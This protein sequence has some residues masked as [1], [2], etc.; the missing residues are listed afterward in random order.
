MID[1]SA[2]RPRRGRTRALVALAAVV[3]TG[4]T[5]PRQAAAQAPDDYRRMTLADLLEVEVSTVTRYPE[6]ARLT[7]AAVHVITRD[8]IRRSGATSLAELLR[9]APGV[10]VARIDAGK[11]AIGVRGFADRLSRS[12]LV[13]ID[14]RAVYTPLFAGTYWEVQDT[15]LEDIERIEVIRGPGGTLWGSNAVNGIINIVTRPAR[16]TQGVLVS[17]SAGTHDR[18]QGAFRIGGALGDGLF[19]RGYVKAFDSVS[20]A[21]VAGPSYDGWTMAQVGFRL[22]ADAAGSRHLT[23]QGDAYIARLGQF[24]RTSLFAPPY[25]QTSTPELPLGGGN[26]LARWSAPAGADGDYQLQAYYDRARRQEYPVGETR[27]T[28]DLDYQQRQRRWP[29]QEVTWGLGYRAAAA[30]LDTADISSL[31]DGTEHLFSGFA[32][33]EITLVPGELVATLGARLEHNPYSGLEVQPS[34]RVLWEVARD[35]TVWGA[36]TRA[37]RRPSRVEREYATTSVLNPS[38]P[39]FIRLRPNAEFRSETLTAYE[40]GY[41]V[42]A[43][44]RAFVTLSTFFNRMDDLLT[45]ELDTPFVEQ[46]PA[47][48]RLIFPVSFRNGLS[49][50]SRGLEATADADPTDRWRIGVGYAYL[51]VDVAPDPG[52]TDITQESRYEDGSPRHQLDL[53]NAVDLPAGMVLDWR[54]RYV[55]SLPDLPVPAYATSDLR[56]AWQAADGLE[57]EAVGRNLHHG[58][59][60]EWTGDNG[61]ADVE[62]ERS[63]YVGF[64]W[65]TP[66]RDP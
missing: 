21:P 26:V 46:T 35:H 12:M 48:A 1:A 63:L 39:A 17:A 42:R 60:L 4:A 18:V 36:V 6:P 62:I 9:L 56:V 7:P 57:L 55:S 66:R 23:V 10:Q 20:H 28:F 33:D 13:L 52:S 5:V 64:T 51:R 2:G 31:P 40:A 22:D 54:L 11:W 16:E 49:G 29:R 27:D 38:G 47:P 53:R 8:D 3:L 59:H 15:L 44:T 32:Q 14:G 25:L 34:G 43:G 61:G 19:A 45:T 41:R 30:D 65:T 24:Q 37:V 50:H 58:G